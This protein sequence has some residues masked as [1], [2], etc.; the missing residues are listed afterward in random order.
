[1][2]F[3]KFEVTEE[4]RSIIDR[5][6]ETD[7]MKALPWIKRLTMKTAQAMLHNQLQM[8]IT[9]SMKGLNLEDVKNMM[10]GITN[11]DQTKIEEGLFR[12]NPEML[13]QLAELEEKNSNKAE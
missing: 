7:Y 9:E 13:K 5:A 8:E 2:P 6:A 4:E 11:N 10:E 3:I 12:N 1:M